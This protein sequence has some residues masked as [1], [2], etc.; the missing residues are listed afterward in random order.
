MAHRKDA[1]QA[2]CNARQALALWRGRPLDDLSSEPADGWRTRVVENEWIPANTTLLQALLDTGLSDEALSLLNDLQIDH[3]HDIRLTKLR[4]SVLHALRRPVEQAAYYLNVRRRLLQEA[5]TRTADLIRRHHEQL[6]AEP[7]DER[8]PAAG[9]TLVPRQLPHDV[10]TFVGRGE[11]LAALDAGADTP[12]ED[13]APG[14][15]VIV[16]GMAGAGKTALVVHWARRNR[17]RFPGGDFYV[18]LNG[19]SPSPPISHSTVVDDLL[20]ALGYPPDKSHSQRS[21]E[22][23]LSQLFADRRALIVLDNARDTAH[24]QRLVPLLSNCLIIVTSRQ[25]LTTLSTVT[26]A[27]RVRVDPMDLK[28]ATAMLSARLDPRHNIGYQDSIQ[29]ARLCGGLPL[30]I[31]VL[32]EHIGNRRSAHLAAFI[33]SLT[34][35][36][37]IAEIGHDG[38]RVTNAQTMFTW[39]YHALAAPERRLFRLLGLHPGSDISTATAAAYDGRTPGETSRSLGVLVGANLLEQPLTFDRYQFH[40]L[41]RDFAVHC[42][43]LDEPP[44]HRRETELRMIRHYMRATTHA[45]KLLY[46]GRSIPPAISGDGTESSVFP[47]A[48]HARSW[49]DQERSNLSPVISYA[50]ARGHHAHAWRLADT[51]AT[52][53]DRRGYYLDSRAIRAIAVSSAAA[54]G[55]SEAEAST[56]T[57]LGMV[58]MILGEHAEARRCLDAALRFAEETGNEMGQGSALHQLGR[59]QMLCGDIAAAV[60]L[61]RRCL[62]VNQRLNDRQGLSWTHC[63]LGEAL[64]KLDRHDEALLHLQQAQFHAQQNE[65][66]AAHATALAEIGSVYRDRGDH[67]G[68]AAHCEEALKIVDSAPIADLA[69]TIHGCRALAEIWGKLKEYDK[70]IE[71]ASR[72]VDIGRATR[73]VAAEC[74]SLDVLGEIYHDSGELQLAAEAWQQAS[75]LYDKLGNLTR[76]TTLRISIRRIQARHPDVPQARSVQPQPRS[77]AH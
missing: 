4:L 74:R 57:G 45:H 43:E 29:L 16:D 28:D 63:R 24:V 65:D 34:T 31:S 6:A 50:A 67:R 22:I 40:D 14:G 54:S 76:A 61:F 68:A 11:L 39:S 53:F 51:A 10:S 66:T 21:K 30:V 38:D 13:D 3:G 20:I 62:A 56:R 35:R 55:D 46:P 36:D 15:I 12:A 32:A 2:A 77:W 5:D 8:A 47:D 59:L 33:R 18:N 42:A 75:V 49:F 60:T 41:L 27:R 19:F 37:L 17:R 70:A 64:R 48:N 72:A 9:P 26:G 73:H 44:P 52:L 25:R 1:E 23:L 69:I 71:Y 58:L 7:D